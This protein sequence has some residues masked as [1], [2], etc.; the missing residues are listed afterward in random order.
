MGY[1]LLETFVGL[2][3][4]IFSAIPVINILVYK[5]L[6][7]FTAPMIFGFSLVQ[8]IILVGMTYLGL[9]S[10]QGRY[11]YV[12]WISNIIDSNVGR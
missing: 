1:F 4:S 10:L 3:V 2:L 8:F 7:L 9:T 6:F 12:P 5:L 11:S